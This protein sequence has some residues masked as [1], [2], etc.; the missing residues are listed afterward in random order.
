MN[1]ATYGSRHCQKAP[2]PAGSERRE[3]LKQHRLRQMLNL[4][5]QILFMS[6]SRKRFNFPVFG[7]S[8]HLQNTLA[9]VLGEYLPIV[10]RFHGQ[11]TD[12]D[13]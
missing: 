8:Q 10:L 2:V 7:R 12:D 1:V 6:N 5:C 4:S 3:T 11:F 9:A 13:A